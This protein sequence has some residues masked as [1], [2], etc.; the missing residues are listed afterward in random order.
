MRIAVI[1]DTH[2]MNKDIIE[3]LVSMDKPDMLIHLGDYVDDGEKISKVLGI[4]ITIVA[5]NGDPGSNYDED[6]LIEINGKKLFL[7]HGHRYKVVRNLDTLYY[8][9]MEMGADIALY[10]HTHVPVNIVYDNL[11]I[12]NPGSP[13]LP[14][15]KSSIKTF[16]LIRIGKEI[17]TEIVSVL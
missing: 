9:A 1:S 15:S 4:P 16:G 2:G 7:T 13:S 17:E 5:G 8:K 12:M 6:Q 11:I 14:R 10:G 3:T